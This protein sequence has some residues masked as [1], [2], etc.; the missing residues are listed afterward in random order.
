MNVPD[1]LR[2]TQDHEWARRRDAQTVVVGITDYAQDALGDITYLELPDV[3]REVQAGAACGVVE[4]V[5]TFSDIYAPVGG[6][7]VAVNDGL[8]D[9]EGAVNAS[10]YDDG[11][12]FAIEMSDESEW[13]GLLDARAYRDLVE[14]EGG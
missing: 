5:K 14:S 6:K 2:Y 8:S 10:P 13:D 9:N 11:W 7:I 12:L 1:D 3:G 4:S